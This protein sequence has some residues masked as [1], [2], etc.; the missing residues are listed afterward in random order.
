[1]EKRI[2]RA[3]TG[4]RYSRCDFGATVEY[5]MAVFGEEDMV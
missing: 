4:E 3:L 1:M 5:G 2:N